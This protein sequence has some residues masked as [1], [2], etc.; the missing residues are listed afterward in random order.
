MMVDVLLYI[1]G[2]LI[3]QYIFWRRLREDYSKEIIFSSEYC[4]LFCLLVAALASAKFFPAWWFWTDLAGIIFGLTVAVAWF[5]LR[6]FETAMRK[7]TITI[8]D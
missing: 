4:I 3:F 2:L 5:H 6:I 8:P 7:Y 1:L